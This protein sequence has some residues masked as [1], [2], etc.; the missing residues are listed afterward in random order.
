[1][2]N[3]WWSNMSC[4]VQRASDLKDSKTLYGLLTQ[5]FGPSSSSTVPLK[6]KDNTTLIKDPNK[7]LGR[8]HEHFKDLFFNPSEVDND[9]ID[10]LPQAEIRHHLDRIPTCEEVDVAVKQL[11]SGKASVQV[12][13]ELLQ[14]GSKNVLHAI[15][16]SFV[17]CWDGTPIPQD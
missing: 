12:P 10:N 17:N 9:A 3:L 6:S 7:I 2:K 1:M 8:W 5:V 11:N 14:T 13:V 4:N 16:E 15:H